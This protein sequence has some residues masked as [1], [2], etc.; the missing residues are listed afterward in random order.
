MKLMEP[1]RLICP[2]QAAYLLG[3]KVEWF[4]RN[5]K[6]LEAELHFPKPLLGSDYDP[7]AIMAWRLAQMDPALRAVLEAAALTSPAPTT[8]VE[9]M[10]VQEIDWADELDRRAKKFAAAPIPDAAE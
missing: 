8:A 1:M 7:L 2:S 4:Y 10:R 3:R 9:V 6:W 5:R